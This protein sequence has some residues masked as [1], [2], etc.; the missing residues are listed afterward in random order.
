MNQLFT[1]ISVY[2]S[3][4]RKTIIPI[5]IIA[6]T[7]FVYWNIQS[8][9]FINFD[10][11]QYVAENQFVQKGISLD[12]IKWAFGFSK[13]AI[14]F[15]WHPLTWISHMTDCHFFGLNAGMHHLTSLLIHIFNT[16]LLFFIFHQM[17]GAFW[18]SALIA[19]LFAVH[20]INVDS[21]A[22]IAERK[23]VL[24]TLF[25][26]ITMLAYIYY[27]RRPGF[28]RYL[29]IIIPF[30]LGLASKPM[31]VTLPCVLLLIDFWPLGRMN[32]FQS[33]NHFDLDS[34]R[35][36]F[37]EI[38]VRHLIL[39]K[40]PLFILS[41][42]TVGISVL[43]VHITQQIVPDDAIPMSLRTANALVSYIKY[44]V[45]IIWPHDLAVFYPFPAAIP[46]WQPAAA[47]LILTGISIGILL[48]IKKAPY[49]L[50]GWLWYLGTLFPVIGIFQQGLWPEMSDRWAYVPQ[51]GLFIIFSWGSF[52]IISRVPRHK[53]IVSFLT[54][55]IIIALML[56]SRHQASYWA[57]SATLFRHNLDVTENNPVAHFYLGAA[58][59]T[60]GQ[61]DQA[62]DH[63]Y[64]SL[65][66]KESDEVHNNLGNALAQ[67]GQI[68]QAIKHINIA[69]KKNPLNHQ[70]LNNM[71]NV[72]LEMGEPDNAIIYFN[73]ALHAAPQI[74]E[75][76][77]NIGNA[78]LQKNM[79]NEAISHFNIILNDDPYHI[80]ANINMGVALIRLNRIDA[81]ITHYQ[82][83][84]KAAP[85]I[86]EAHNNLG[87]LLLQK[88]QSDEAKT[89]FETAIRL[90]PGYANARSNLEKLLTILKKK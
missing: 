56:V 51:I 59:A 12:N 5:F 19:T 73:R 6:V 64:Q 40:I 36:S 79:P 8:F 54:P 63:Y 83:A 29:L 43:S 18:R 65:A 88:G 71:G 57:N 67:K 1:D 85:E 34:G 47:G 48:K 78:L 24:N 68:D 32:L 11:D 7:L 2:S 25:W 46:A 17:T 28:R 14:N 49:L 4:F 69:L 10:D 72:F 52:A 70:A 84:L 35:L 33:G 22:W 45:K 26:M 30:M 77:N 53:T 87:V 27:A 37:Q 80:E 13:E 81:A 60:N 86:A 3:S 41:F 38:P 82:A 55:A 61:I 9:D 20:P 39:E 50:T 21:V 90:R 62:I 42:I 76:H 15:Y 74:T 23:N 75:I 66:L 31:L 16:L 44:I 58:L 89:H